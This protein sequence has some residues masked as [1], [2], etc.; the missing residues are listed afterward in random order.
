MTCRNQFHQCQHVD[1]VM[2]IMIQFD[3]TDLMAQIIDRI[4]GQHYQQQIFQIVVEHQPRK[5]PDELRYFED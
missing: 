5:N 4:D 1:Y 2:L 3:M